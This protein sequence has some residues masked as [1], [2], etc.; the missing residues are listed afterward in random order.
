MAMSLNK[1][2]ELV[3]DREACH[4][5]VHGVAKSWTQL[6]NWT[7][8]IFVAVLSIFCYVWYFYWNTGNLVKPPFCF[9]YPTFPFA[10]DEAPILWAPDVKSS[11]EK[12]LLLGKI[13]G[14]MRREWQRMRWLDG[15]TNSVDMSL[16]KLW[17][18]VKDR[19]VLCTADHG[20]TK[21]QTQHRDW[22]TATPT[23][24]RSWF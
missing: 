2:Q 1:L 15:I 17:E 8:L 5:T 22:T 12:S 10:E 14:R 20:V 19:E 16:R 11:L 9:I 3:M 13:E 6:S 21:H 23:F 18:I 4:A 7:E 24:Q